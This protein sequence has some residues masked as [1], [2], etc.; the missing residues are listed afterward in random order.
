MQPPARKLTF[1]PKFAGLAVA[2][3]LVELG[4]AVFVHDRFVRPFLGDVLVV[5][6]IFLVCR[7]FLVVNHRYLALGVLLFAFAIEL[8]QYFN[9]VRALGLQHNRLAHR[10]IG[11]RFDVRDLLAYTAGIALLLAVDALVARCPQLEPPRQ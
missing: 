7:T 9:L 5:I 6:L 1:A 8:G 10:V 4:I 3:L 2:L 11:T